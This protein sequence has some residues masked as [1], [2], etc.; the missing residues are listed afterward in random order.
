MLQSPIRPPDRVAFGQPLGR[1]PCPDGLDARLV[2]SVLPTA[3]GLRAL[4]GLGSSLGLRRSGNPFLPCPV[5]LGRA[6]QFVAS[7][8]SHRPRCARISAQAPHQKCIAFGSTFFHSPVANG[9]KKGLPE[10]RK[11][12][13]G[14]RGYAPHIKTGR[15]GVLCALG[16]A[17]L[18]GSPRPRRAR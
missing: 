4:T 14:R 3:F 5:G 18:S 15:W 10:R 6:M 11:P 13:P 1:Q 9:L 8:S 12:A 7:D 2:A 17:I 16:R